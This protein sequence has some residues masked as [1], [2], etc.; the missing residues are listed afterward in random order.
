VLA[1]AVVNSRKLATQFWLS[2][3]IKEKKD[4][5]SQTSAPN[6]IIMELEQ[7]NK[8]LK[9]MLDNQKMRNERITVELDKQ[10][11]EARTN[12]IKWEESQLKLVEMT[13]MMK[14]AKK[15]ATVVAGLNKEIHYCMC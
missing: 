8:F 4:F 9:G 12:N 13:A 3:F 10:Q 6:T 5:S 7:D 15:D 11:K 14:A 2:V 1:R